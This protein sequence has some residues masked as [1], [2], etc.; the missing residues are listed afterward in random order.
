MTLILIGVTRVISRLITAEQH[1]ERHVYNAT[2]R[3]EMCE[4]EKIIHA[5]KMF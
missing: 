5:V 2:A 4:L 3:A 1:K